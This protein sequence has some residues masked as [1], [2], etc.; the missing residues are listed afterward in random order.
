MAKFDVVIKINGIVREVKENTARLFSA[1]MTKNAGA[2]TPTRALQTL[3]KNP[4]EWAEAVLS[5]GEASDVIEVFEG[6]NLKGR[7]TR[8]K[9]VRYVGVCLDAQNWMPE[10]FGESTKTAKDNS[11][12]EVI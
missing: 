6:E 8:A 11:E 12:A 10:T 7:S 4:S 3:T 5:Q 1:L 2:E 9:I